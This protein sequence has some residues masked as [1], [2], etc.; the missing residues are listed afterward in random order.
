MPTTSAR[1]LGVNFDSALSMR[2]HIDVISARCYATIRQLR[3]IRRCASPAVVQSLVTSLVLSRLDYCNSVLYGLPAIIV[4]RLQLVQNAAACLVFNIRRPE[5]VTDALISLHWLRV[6]ERI[7]FKMAVMAFRSI[8]GLR[9]HTCTAS[10]VHPDWSSWFAIGCLKPCCRPTY[11]F[12]D[13]WRP[14]IPVA[15]AEVWND[16]PQRMSHPLRLSV[17]SVLA[18]K[19]FCLTIHTLD[20]LY[21]DRFPLDLS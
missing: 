1:N 2:R 19:H 17:S 8:N 15:G 18:S 20:W 13:D 10:S 9:Q 12:V 16:L 14:G 11:S 4:H 5:H 3:A 6:A 7:R 21:R